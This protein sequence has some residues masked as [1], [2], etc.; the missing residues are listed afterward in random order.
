[1]PW[2]PIKWSS[3]FTL[4]FVLCNGF[5]HP[6]YLVQISHPPDIIFYN[7]IDKFIINQGWAKKKCSLFYVK[8][9]SNFTNLTIVESSLLIRLGFSTNGCFTFINL[10]RT[11]CWWKWLNIH[12]QIL[13]FFYRHAR[14]F[15][16][17]VMAFYV[18]Y[19]IFESCT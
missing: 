18:I 17:K 4:G 16:A 6:P 13:N 15:I 10:K 14:S 9:F 19:S 7:Q 5:Y 12:G 1:M 8:N 3:Q 11:F 2:G